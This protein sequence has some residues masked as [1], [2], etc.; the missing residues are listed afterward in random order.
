MTEMPE[1]EAAWTALQASGLSSEDSVRLVEGVTEVPETWAPLRDRLPFEGDQAMER[2][3]LLL[4]SAAYEPRIADCPVPESVKQRL[5]QEHQQFAKARKQQPLLMGSSA[6]VSACKFAT[7]RRFPAGPLD[8]EVSGFPRSWLARVGW[9]APKMGA[10]LTAHIGGF[11]PL[12]FTHVARPPY[13]RSLVL[14]REVLRTYHR[15]ARAM[16]MQPEIKG[17]MTAAWFHDPA[18]VKDRPHLEP[19]NRV[20]LQ[21]GGLI[22]T[23]PAGEQTE[24]DHPVSAKEGIAVI[25]RR[26]LLA[27][28]DAHAEYDEERTTV[29]S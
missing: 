8:W 7:L 1:L 23:M 28:A 10:Y 6:F 13:N 24:A 18:M 16:S 15:I 2:V 11:S 26:E 25:G 14:E 5:R 29:N 12:F 20:Y 17:L 21:G 19:L 4:A 9:E 27:W 22:V 3:L